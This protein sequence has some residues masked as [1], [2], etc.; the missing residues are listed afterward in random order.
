[1]TTMPF[2]LRRANPNKPLQD[3]HLHVLSSSLPKFQRRRCIRSTCRMCEALS[4]HLPKQI[5]SPWRLASDSLSP[6]PNSDCRSPS[7]V[8]PI[9][10][11]FSLYSILLFGIIFYMGVSP[12]LIKLFYLSKKKNSN[13]ILD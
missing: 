11:I 12:S 13:Y 3:T 4:V 9:N 7:P 5:S 8:T 10:H 2:D 6:H 1:M